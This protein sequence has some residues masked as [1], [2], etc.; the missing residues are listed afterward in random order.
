MSSP[1]FGS[2]SLG[3]TLDAF[4]ASLLY[5]RNNFPVQDKYP[6]NQFPSILHFPV[7]RLSITPSA[8]AGSSVVS[9]SSFMPSARS[10][11]IQIPAG[12]SIDMDID[13]PDDANLKAIDQFFDL[14]SLAAS[15]GG[16]S[17]HEF[18]TSRLR[19]HL[20]P[21]L[22]SILYDGQTI[23]KALLSVCHGP[24][25][26]ITRLDGTNRPSEADIAFIGFQTAFI[27][28]QKLVELG[29]TGSLGPAE[30]CASYPFSLSIL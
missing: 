11:A 4:S 13:F 18:M 7:P 2:P 16:D 21:A 25:Q 27:M 3:S 5:W 26:D 15:F 6:A 30:R 8:I 20:C 17:L 9:F 14:S 1:S 19:T 12:N 23:T 10:P 28:H 24:W 29:L 22:L